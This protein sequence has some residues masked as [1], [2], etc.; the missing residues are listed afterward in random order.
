MAEQFRSLKQIR[1]FAGD[2]EVTEGTARTRAVAVSLKFVASEYS[3]F[4]MRSPKRLSNWFCIW[5]WYCAACVNSVAEI[6]Q[7]QVLLITAI[8]AGH[9]FHSNQVARKIK[10]FDL[11]P[12]IVA[13]YFTA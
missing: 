2:R 13:R 7:T 10:P 11:A 8:S 12:T 5:G 6:S 9:G 4:K 3:W 1:S